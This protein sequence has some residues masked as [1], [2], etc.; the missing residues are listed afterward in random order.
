MKKLI[1][2]IFFLTGLLFFNSSNL[3]SQDACLTD[4]SKLIDTIPNYQKSW[5]GGVRTGP[6]AVV[7]VD[8]PDGRYMDDNGVLKQPMEDSEL[9]LVANKDAVGE[10]GVIKVNGQYQLKAAKYTLQ[11]RWNMLFD[12]DGIYQGKAHPD[13]DSHGDLAYG[14][15][16]DYW[17]EAS[18]GKFEL[19]PYVTHPDEI[20]PKLRTGIINDYQ[21]VNGRTI[22]NYIMLPI[23]KYGS[24]NSNSYM[25]GYDDND[26]VITKFNKIIYAA[27]DAVM[28]QTNFDL[29]SFRNNGGVLMIVYAGSSL[30]FKGMGDW[31]SKAFAV[32]NMWCWYNTPENCRIDGFGITAHEYAHLAFSWGHVVA[33][34]YCIMNV[35]DVHDRNSPQLPNPLYRIQQGWIEPIEIKNSQDFSNLE[36]I[37]TSYKCGAVTIYGKPNYFPDW[38]GG[39]YFIRF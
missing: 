35:N 14:S 11:D 38:S 6:I 9:D 10:M 18:N 32:R 4:C 33:G 23:N 17:K 2:L 21:V 19:T 25:R 31:A 13:Y 3:F 26:D 34:R 15:M 22:I 28:Q 5:W 8:F 37:E 39:E 29:V 7:Y 30:H 24:D 1:H 20:D 16:F 12:R 36:P 27:E